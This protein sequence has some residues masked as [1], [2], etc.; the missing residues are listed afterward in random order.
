[1]NNNDE[2]DYAEEVAN[3]S[4]MVE[5]AEPTVQV[6]MANGSYDITGLTFHQVGTILYALQ[7]IGSCN[8]TNKF[9]KIDAEKLNDVLTSSRWIA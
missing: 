8:T 1:M 3:R 7:H 9:N 4:S 2:R 5:A 6:S